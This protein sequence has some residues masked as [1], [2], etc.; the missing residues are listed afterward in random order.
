VDDQGEITVAASAMAAQLQAHPEIT[1]IFAADGQGATGSVQACK[2][3]GRTDIKIMTVDSDQGILDQISAG[4]LYG[5]VAQNTFNMGYWAMMQMYVYAHD[6]V[7]P[8]NNWRAE[9]VSPMPPY[10]NSGVDV[11]TKANASSFVVPAN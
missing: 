3:A 7:D 11:V 4:E 8:F 5:T 1:I 9:K 10:I 6:L 2:E